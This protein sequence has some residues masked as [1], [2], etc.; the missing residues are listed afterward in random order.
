VSGGIPLP[1]REGQVSRQAH[2]DLPAGSYEREIGREG[3]FGPAAHVYHRHPPTNWSAIEGP[4]R[5]RAYDS[6]RLAAAHDCPWEVPTLFGNAHVKV[7]RWRLAQPM[8]Q[9]ARNADGDELFFVHA[10][11]AELFCD[12]GHLALR[13][14][15]Y[16]VLPRGTLWRLVC[17]APL[18]LLAIEA[19]GSRYQLPDRGLLGAHAIFDPAALETP[20][21]DDAFRAQQDER[22]WQ[23]RVKARGQIS[24]ITYPFNPLDAIGWKGDLA[25]VRLDRRDI[26]PVVSP[27]Y[28]LPPSV[29]ATFVAER[30]VVCTFCPRPVESD[31]G[32]LPLPFYHS[33]DDYDELLFYHR[34]AFLSRQGQGLGAGAISLHPA[35]CTHGPHPEALAAAL[36]RERT[37]TDEV[38]VML[39]ARDPL[40]IGAAAAA[41]EIAGYAETWSAR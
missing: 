9:L 12:F 40:E 18:E 5:P 3:F 15:H 33:N 39:D 29:H 21:L 31:P 38:A 41:L 11:E 26:R 36:R 22:E 20:T 8:T 25:P 4:L 28:H 23:V 24:T 7:R 37:D 10:G 1:R 19:T 17:D 32:A 14:G 35:G 34:G 30:F 27:R 13:E 16:L 6:A 2:A